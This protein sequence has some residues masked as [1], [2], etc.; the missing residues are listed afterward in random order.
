LPEVTIPKIIWMNVFILDGCQGKIL[1]S[2]E[3]REANSMD[4]P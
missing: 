4:T 1:L 2:E 3:R